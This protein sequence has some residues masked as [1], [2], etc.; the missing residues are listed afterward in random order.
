MKRIKDIDKYLDE[1]IT[2]VIG[3]Y[4]GVETNTEVITPCSNIECEECLFVND[5]DCF[6]KILE[7]LKKGEEE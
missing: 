5:D 7:W 3:F 2:D 4:F 1:L 6:E